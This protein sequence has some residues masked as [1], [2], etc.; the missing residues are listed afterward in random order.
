MTSSTYHIEKLLHGGLGLGRN[1]DKQKMLIEGVISGETVAAKIQ[2]LKKNRNTAVATSIIEPSSERIKAPCQYYKQCGGC[3]FQHMN[4]PRQLQEKQAILKDLLQQSGNTI[5]QEAAT[6]ILNAPLPSPSQTHYRQRIRLQVDNKQTLGFHK[7]RSH[8]CVAI[9]SCLLA[10]PKINDCLQK[11]LPQYAFNKLL[12]QTETVEILFDPDSS[13]VTLLIQFKRKPR[14][15]DKQHA[16]DLINTISELTNIFFIGDGFSVTG[17]ASLSFTLPPLVPHTTKTVQLSL[18]TGGFCQVNVEQNT[19][20]VKTVLD[21][22]AVTKK[23]TILDLFCGMGNFSIPLAERS[24]SVLGIEGQGSAIR[25]AIRNSSNAGQDNTIFKKQPIHAACSELA[26][27]GS[28]FDCIILDPPRQG[29]P[30]LARVL[31]ALCRKRLVYISC[32]PVTLC[33]DLEDLL[34]YGFVIKK[35]QPIDMFPQTHHI[36]TVALLETA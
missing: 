8:D 2:S 34:Q 10:T 16:Q 12:N 15:A 18:E 20:L 25:S 11:L 30:G 1:E 3:D 14:P 24:Q 5:L 28:L 13:T 22:C 17:N 21:F 29:A 23:D 4:Y 36:E 35:L 32:D 31:S 6:Q 7:R 9:E 26:K 27:A 33:R 19:N